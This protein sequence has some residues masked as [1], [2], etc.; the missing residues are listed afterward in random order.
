MH[1]LA[2]LLLVLIGSIDAGAAPVWVTPKHRAA[3]PSEMLAGAPLAPVSPADVPIWSTGAML[4]VDLG[5]DGAWRGDLP[6]DVAGDLRILPISQAGDELTLTLHDGIERAPIRLGPASTDAISEITEVPGVGFF[7]GS[8]VPVERAST[9]RVSIS[10]PPGTRIAYL[11]FSTDSSVALRSAR[12]TDR[13]VVGEP[14][15]FRASMH[16]AV[17]APAFGGVAMDIFVTTPDGERLS[18]PMR[19]ERDGASMASFVPEVPGRYLVQTVA[20]GDSFVRTAQHIVS[21]VAD[22]VAVGDSASASMR[23]AS[24]TLR[25]DIEAHDRGRS[26]HCR[27]T[28]QLWGRDDQG[29]AVPVCWVGG[30]TTLQVHREGHATLPIDVDARWISRAE[31]TRPFE[32]R[33]VEVRCP[34]TMALLSGA[35]SLPLRLDEL[36]PRM[37]A[38]AGILPEMRTAPRNDDYAFVVDVDVPSG[39]RVAGGHNLLLIHGYCAGGNPWP[40][41]D[42][43]GAL[44]VFSDPEANRSHDEFALLIKALADT[45]KSSGVVAHSQGGCAALHLYTYYFSALDWAEGPRLIQSLGTPYQGTPIAGNLGALGEIFG[46]GCGSNSDLSVDGATTWLSGIP[47]DARARVHYWTTSSDGPWCNFFSGLF[48]TNP[49]DG[50][51]EVA[52]GQ[53]PGANSM[54]NTVGQCH[55]TGM[56]DPAQYQDSSRNSEMNANAAR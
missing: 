29:N 49:E 32:L 23:D 33:R 38:P 4:R 20:R 25:I 44:E 16:A 45:T 22:D 24:H 40:L 39:D 53:L 41:A 54:G 31:A 18:L 6:V 26:E 10:A 52:R 48:L 35:D 15:A 51:I 13:T 1:R 9:W 19:A 56:S 14:I 8:I 30:M 43:S 34:R 11:A 36:L 5:A 46:A 42:F 28:A 12:V 17:G 47:S 55:T 27:V 37:A 7:T 21:V 3:P 2:I 50:V